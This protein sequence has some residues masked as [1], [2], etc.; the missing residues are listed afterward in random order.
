MIFS[1]HPP[2]VMSHP[3]HHHCADCINSHLCV[4]YMYFLCL[5][6]FIFYFF[7]ISLNPVLFL[8]LFG[9]VWFISHIKKKTFLFITLFALTLLLECIV[10]DINSLAVDHNVI[11]FVFD[12]IRCRHATRSCGSIWNHSTR[13]AEAVLRLCWGCAGRAVNNK[14]Y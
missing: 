8:Y 7:F 4:K 1:P 14:A 9:F 11:M 13:C 6:W 3:R 2:S 10:G 12:L 5:S